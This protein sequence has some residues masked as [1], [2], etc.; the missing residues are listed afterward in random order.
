MRST[1]VK[2]L[3]IPHTYNE[4]E[5]CQSINT[6]KQ[7]ITQQSLALRAVGWPH[8][9]LWKLSWSH[10]RHSPPA[11]MCTDELIESH[12]HLLPCPPPLT[13]PSFPSHGSRLGMGGKESPFSTAVLPRPPMRS[14]REEGHKPSTDS[15]LFTPQKIGSYLVV[16]TWAQGRVIL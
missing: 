3:P 13:S 11:L 1:S 16:K 12:S 9:I 5:H 6:R 8:S 7:L 10:S 4:I 15:H 2:F 14:L